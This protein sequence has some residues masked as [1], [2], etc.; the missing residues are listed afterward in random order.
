MTHTHNLFGNED[1]DLL[2]ISHKHSAA[3]FLNQLL[4]KISNIHHG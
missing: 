4:N 3:Q 1:Q 2:G